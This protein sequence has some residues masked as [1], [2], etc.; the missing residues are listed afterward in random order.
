M[1]RQ[2][3]LALHKKVK[4]VKKTFLFF[5][6]MIFSLSWMGC[7]KSETAEEKD[8]HKNGFMRSDKI[9]EDDEYYV[10]R[11]DPINMQKKAEGSD[12]KILYG[13]VTPKSWKGKTYRLYAV[14]T[15]PIF[16][17][18]KWILEIY[19]TE[20][21]ETETK[22]ITY[23]KLG[24]TG[25]DDKNV[26]DY[27][28]DVDWIDDNYFV[29]QYVT[30]AKEE[31]RYYQ[32]SDKRIYTDLNG[33]IKQTELWDKFETNGFLI[34]DY[35]ESSFIPSGSC[36]CDGQGATYGLSKKAD[37]TYLW[38][39]DR[40]GVLIYENLIP[41]SWVKKDEFKTDQNEIVYVFYDEK[42]D[43]QHFIWIDA[44]NRKS[45]EIATLSG[46]EKISKAWGM[47]QNT[48]YYEKAQERKA[49]SW[50]IINGK[51]KL[52][53]DYVKNSISPTY[54]MTYIFRKDAPPAIRLYKNTDLRSGETED[55]IVYL[56]KEKVDNLIEVDILVTD[57]P[58]SRQIMEAASRSTKK[59]PNNL[60]EC[61]KI[62]TN[63]QKNI[64]INEL[65]S[66]NGPDVLY[67]SRSDF[68]TFSEKGLL[69]D[70]SEVISK[71]TLSNILPGA[72]ELGQVSDKQY[73]IPTCVSASGL[74]VAKTVWEKDTWTY[75]DML[76]LMEMQVL[77]GNLFYVNAGKPFAPLATTVLLTARNY[78]SWLID[79]NRK[80]CN[81]VDKRF[82]D[83]LT[84][85]KSAPKQSGETD[86]W[87]NAGSRMAYVDINTSAFIYD[88]GVREELEEGHYVGFP[89]NGKNGNYLDANGVLVINI[90]AKNM[91]G[92]INLFECI[93]DPE[94]QNMAEQNTQSALS[95]CKKERREFSYD[96][97]G[98][99]YCDGNEIRIL[100]NGKTTVE[101]A[102]EFLENCVAAPFHEP[103][104]EKILMEELAVYYQGDR[105]AR[106]TAEII[107]QRAQLFL[108]E[109]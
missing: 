48:L 69:K 35:H 97:D 16:E 15:P 7:N 20:T 90:S 99:I 43:K 77:E 62:E 14:I 11:Y 81:F 39:F 23:E 107:Q 36:I 63:E 60:F 106:E 34:N 55:W 72:L 33:N 105:S 102:E 30:V 24:L 13:N 27:L 86:T 45:T 83:L 104:I 44:A 89:T 28:V 65:M 64:L 68:I 78:D 73:G 5:V 2:I 75:D 56:S 29:F 40:E 21:K 41:Q 98:K 12:G 50:D 53:I 1:Q 38:V 70:L 9:V 93:L 82:I 46:E 103:E 17:A 59:N 80:I 18:S 57:D 66:G 67:L 94:I 3:L 31:D 96:E 6:I 95:I 47:S 22:E 85:L 100:Q 37:G 49:Y 74:L 25:N 26:L 88:F 52:F 91:E 92:I 58:G 8:W 109:K 108:N 4:H 84:I 19:D 61:K 51:Q 101:Y 79:W 42:E 71:E 10:E 76:H 32:T 87:L 54:G